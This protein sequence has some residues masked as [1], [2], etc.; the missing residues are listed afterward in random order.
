MYHKFSSLL[1]SLGTL[2]VSGRSYVEIPV[3]A[4]EQVS[5]QLTSKVFQALH[6]FTVDEKLT[7]LV[8][9]LMNK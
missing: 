3:P 4:F 8:G 1:Y 9:Y 6:G 5:D 7:S 2:E